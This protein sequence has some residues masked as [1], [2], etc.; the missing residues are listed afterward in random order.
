MR[1]SPRVSLGLP[2]FN[3]EKYLAQTLEAIQTQT[4]EDFELIVSDNA[5]TDRTQEIVQSFAGS[6]NRIC[7]HRNDKNLGAAPNFNLVFELA[8]GQ[9]FKWIAHD[10]IIAPDFL[11][12]CV[13]V[14]DENPGVV[15]CYSKVILIDASGN[16]ISDYDPEPNA[17][18]QR[19]HE[20][21]R[22]LIFI[23]SQWA[24]V[25][26]FGLLRADTVWQTARIGS[27]PS[28]DEVFVAEVALHGALFE[29]PER[30]FLMRIHPQQ[31]TRGAFTVERD[32]TLWFDTSLRDR[33]FL[34]KW[35]YLRACIRAINNAPLQSYER[36]YCYCQMLRWG[37]RPPHFRAMCKDALLA[38]R[39]LIYG[40]H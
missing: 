39:K 20:R 31:S 4:Y 36:F 22:D 21:F 25:L 11:S 5:S 40:A 27:Y 18:L 26:T 17:T 35:E 6:D 33:T 28:S 8:S 38:G 16:T 23:D 3:G 34:P 12:R 2:V 1:E 9:Y 30:L 15:L 32:R 37:A 14:L 29:I 24:G 10:D 13:N 7:Y 19:P